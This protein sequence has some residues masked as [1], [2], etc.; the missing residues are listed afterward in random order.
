MTFSVWYFQ[1]VA[2][3]GGMEMQKPEFP[4]AFVLSEPGRGWVGWAHRC[5]VPCLL[6]WLKRNWYKA[7][8]LHTQEGKKRDS[9]WTKAALAVLCS[10]SALRALQ[11][12][13]VSLFHVWMLSVARPNKH[14][15][16]VMEIHP[17]IPSR[18]SAVLSSAFS[19]QWVT[20]LLRKK[21]S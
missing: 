15:P 2:W 3:W 17:I 20:L 21:L 13:H 11:Q 1:P 16:A 18:M 7:E 5:S 8:G 14:E 6:P 12:V 9:S 4:E 10:S 19:Y